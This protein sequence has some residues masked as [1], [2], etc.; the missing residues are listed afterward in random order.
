MVSRKGRRKRRGR[1]EE[2]VLY[3]RGLLRPSGK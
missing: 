1:E 2:R 3:G